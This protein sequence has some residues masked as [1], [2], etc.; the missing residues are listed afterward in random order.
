MKRSLFTTGLLEL[1][2]PGMH[3]VPVWLAQRA[4]APLTGKTFLPRLDRFQQHEILTRTRLQPH[5]QWRSQF[6][7]PTFDASATVTDFGDKWNSC[8]E[9][10]SWAQQPGHN[11]A[12]CISVQAIRW[13]FGDLTGYQAKMGAHTKHYSLAPPF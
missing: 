3:A 4:L 7:N 10:T 1:Q 6:W 13:L 5:L 8:L 9:Q 12:H 2:L 11:H